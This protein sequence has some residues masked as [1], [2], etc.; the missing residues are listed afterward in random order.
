MFSFH[1]IKDYQSLLLNGKATCADAVSYYIKNIEQNRHLNAFLE[2]YKEEALER[3]AQLDAK[4]K[5]GDALGKLHGVIIGL[6]DVVSY[7]N[8]KLS[9][10]SRILE[11][12]QAVYNATAVNRLLEEDAVIIGRQ[13]CDE[14]AMGSSNENS[15]Y[16][17]VLN[18][19]DNARVP[20]GSSGGSAVGVQAKLCM[21]SL[22]S[23]TGGSVRQPADFCG[24]VGLKPSYGRVSRYGLIA[25]ASSFDQ[26]GIFANSVEDAGI[27][28][29]VISGKDEFDSTATGN[30]FQFHYSPVKSG[31]K[32]GYFPVTF[33]HPGL[34][35]EI[36]ATQKK[37]I[38]SL[39]EEGLEVSQIEFDLLDYIVPA[40]YILTTAEASSNLA[41]YDGLKYGAQQ[42][43]TDLNEQIHLT[44][45]RFFGK[46][47]QRRIMLGTFVLSEGYYEAYI[48]QAQKVR[49]ILL[50]KIKKIFTEV[51]AI[52][53]PVSPTTAFR[54]GEKSNDPIAMFLADIY[55]VFANLTGIPAISIPLFKHS[56]GMPFGLQVMASH[57]NELALLS[58]AEYLME[59]NKT[60]NQPVSV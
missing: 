52:I 32:I 23:D 47:V 15:A 53:L 6:K 5:A 50:E 4:R 8:H 37:F 51:D 60:A 59:I 33:N 36:A 39:R 12:F 22:G 43:A 35:P 9:A 28:L 14:F 7:R 18:A 42:P 45:S 21:I 44:R 10:G 34:D 3:A 26:I 56:N 25:Y 46:E 2:V 40:Y 29:E 48:M 54:I 27:V 11:N 16:G 13:N 24:V 38:A 31:F 55:T 30:A 49:R 57:S 20:G 1:S 17:N 58:I 19:A 41:R